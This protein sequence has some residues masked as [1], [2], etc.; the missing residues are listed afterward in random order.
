MPGHRIKLT[1]AEEVAE[2]TMAFHFTRPAAF[3]FQAGQT[4]DITLIDPPETDAE[5]NVRT[6]SI[7][8]SPFDDQLMIATRMRDT[9][10]KRILRKARPGLEVDIVGPDGS[11]TLHKDATRPAVFLTGGIGITPFLS[12]V[13]QAVNDKSKREI[14][15][16]NSNRRP[17]DAPFLDLLKELGAQ[18]PHFHFIATMTKMETS[19]QTWAGETGLVDAA[20]LSRHLPHTIRPVYYVAGPPEMVTSMRKLLLTAKVDEEDLRTEEFSGY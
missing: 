5:G 17:E 11:L 19:H 1:K 8:S 4:I 14:Y 13:R 6:F 16:I 20:M 9:A 7:A 15:L 3:E 18:Y 10:F 12:I 2:G